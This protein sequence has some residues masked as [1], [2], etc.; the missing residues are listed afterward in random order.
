MTRYEGHFKILPKEYVSPRS[1][2]STVNIN[3]S[4]LLGT[5]GVY[6]YHYAL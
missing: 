6:G 1:C 3:L 4:S 2:P 5:F